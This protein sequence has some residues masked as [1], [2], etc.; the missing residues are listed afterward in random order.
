M[1][2]DDMD[3]ALQVPPAISFAWEPA[4]SDVMERPPRNRLVDRLVRPQLL[5][6]SQSLAHHRPQ[7]GSDKLL[8][9]E[10]PG[11]L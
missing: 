5:G 7:T 10:Y 8:P 6:Q 4:E 1:T 11:P 9:L 2:D 3:V